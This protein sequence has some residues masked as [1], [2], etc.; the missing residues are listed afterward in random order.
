LNK[1]YS[2]LN[3]EWHYQ[4]IKN[5]IIIEEFIE[6]EDGHA[7]KDYKI[8]CFHGEP[9]FL[10]VASDRDKNCKFDFYDLN[11]NKIP[12]TQ[13]HIHNKKD[14]NKPEKFEE[15]LEICR[16]LSKDFPHVRVDLYY[17]NGNIYFGELTYFH[18]SGMSPFWPKKYDYIF[19]EYFDIS[20]IDK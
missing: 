18:M 20:N 1:D 12:V 16:I 15:M 17:E 3:K 7:P 4:Y 9:K 10:Y 13:T 14:I 2:S 6:T 11:W 19:G 8:F 5:R